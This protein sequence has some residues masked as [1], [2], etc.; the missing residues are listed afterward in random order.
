MT[1]TIASAGSRPPGNSNSYNPL[2]DD[3]LSGS[4]PPGTPVAPSSDLDGAVVPANGHISSIASCAGLAAGAG[5]VGGR[6]LVQFAGPLV[7]DAAEWDALTGETGGLVRGSVY[8]VVAFSGQS[9]KITRTRPSTP[10]DRT[11]PVGIALSSTDMM[12][13]IGSPTLNS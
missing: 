12:V 6:V 7:L 10:G 9:G 11:I 8:Y 4:F 2:V 13:Q 1:D 3:S 5:V